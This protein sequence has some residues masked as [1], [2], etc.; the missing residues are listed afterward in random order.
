MHVKYERVFQAMQ[1]IDDL[2]ESYQSLISKFL[3]KNDFTL[4]KE[5]KLRWYNM[6]PEETGKYKL[7]L[8]CGN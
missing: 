5:K 4:Y 1:A 8:N 6:K 2:Y 3:T 7:Q